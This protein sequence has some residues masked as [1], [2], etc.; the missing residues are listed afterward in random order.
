MKRVLSAILGVV[1]IP[2]L[3]IQIQ[4][5]SAYKMLYYILL[6]IAVLLLIIV[7]SPSIGK[8]LRK[9]IFLL[10]SMPNINVPLRG[11]E[12]YLAK[13]GDFL[14]D[15]NYKV[16]VIEGES[17]LGKTA[18]ISSFI[19]KNRRKLKKQFDLVIWQSLID[20]PTMREV[21]NSWLNIYTDNIPDVG[22]NARLDAFFRKNKKNKRKKIFIVF[23][24]CESI[25]Q[26]NKERITLPEDFLTLVAR[27]VE[28][29]E[30]IVK[31]VITSAIDLK[32]ILSPQINPLVVNIS[33]LSSDILSQIVYDRTE[34]T[35]DENSLKK[36]HGNPSA[37]LLITEIIKSEVPFFEEIGNGNTFVELVDKRMQLLNDNQRKLIELLSIVKYPMTI[38]EIQDL[39]KL[40]P[41]YVAINQF[42]IT[43]LQQTFL[44][45]EVSGNKYLIN[46]ILASVIGTQIIDELSSTLA[47]QKIED[48][49]IINR[50][51]LDYVRWTKTARNNVMNYIFPATVNKL[52]ALYDYD[53]NELTG[54][55][56]IDIFCNLLLDE[57]L[58]LPTNLVTF[59]LFCGGEFTNVTFPAI[60]LI[61]VDF[62]Q[63]HMFNT[64]LSNVNII[65]CQFA[66]RIGSAYAVQFVKENYVVIGLASGSIE[67]RKTSDLLRITRFETHSQPI[68]AICYSEEN[69]RII[70]GG[71]DGRI[72]IYDENL[73]V[74]KSIEMHSQWIWQIIKISENYI[75]TV[76]CGGYIGVIDLKDNNICR[77]FTIPSQRIWKATVCEQKLFLASED[78]ILWT[79]LLADILALQQPKWEIAANMQEPIKACCSC[80]GRVIL[81]CRD[82]KLFLINENGEQRLLANEENCIRDICM[83]KNTDNIITVGDSGMA[84]IYNVKKCKLLSEFRVQSSRTWSIDV[85]SNG[86]AVTV[87]DD[88]TVH[89]WDANENTS[90]RRSCGNGQSLRGVDT[91]HNNNVFACADDFLRIQNRN[92]IEPWKTLRVRKRILG[93]VSLSGNKWACSFDDGI[94]LLGEGQEI[95][96]KFNAHNSAIESIARNAD[97]TM[98]ATGGE[99]RMIKVFNSLGVQQISPKPL[100]NSRIWSLA[101]SPNKL[102][103]ASAGGDFIVAIW[104]VE[105]GNILGSCPGHN[106]LVLSLCWLDDN[107]LVS[108]GTDGTIQ[109]WDVKS[110]SRLGMKAMPCLIR[111]LTTDGRGVVYGVGRS[112]NID[113]GWV[114]IKWDV[115]NDEFMVK[116][117]GINGGS[118]K[119]IM[120][121]NEKLYLGG[122][123]PIWVEVDPVTLDV[124]AQ[125]RIP[126]I[127]TGMKIDKGKCEGVDLE[128]L[129]LLGADVLRR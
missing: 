90:L 57:T 37:A 2:I 11:R 115:Q 85:L 111:G 34:Y 64:D 56:L 65:N 127:Y 63:V 27:L 45:D 43:N 87:G 39:W 107:N 96:S 30:C 50:L 4:I 129:T 35:L 104:D 19:K 84:H 10:E 109:L 83:I 18:I 119:T 124:I 67:L 82:G 98:F 95:T 88:R 28:Y 86:V 80:S 110:A 6:S 17:G 38:L 118:G 125:F 66:D 126:G 21:I 68:R 123:M 99:D 120:L 40:L 94:V 7:E 116:T 33:K 79:C 89:L 52:K 49:S 48:T 32:N 13:I 106:N 128:C 103:L 92:I 47:S 12:N 62:S 20:I 122:D 16:L 23:D 22:F 117:V 70:S 8:I 36:A 97:G 113:M 100:H 81:G 29:Q 5:S 77:K 60:S 112:S 54:D 3:L 55:T 44:L 75:L 9:T 31:I 61:G 41:P 14:T 58:F 73:V 71:E 24:N 53:V 15:K 108:A 102:K 78:G 46:P 105:T 25:L 51:P 91:F 76:A 69:G 59:F 72:V 114:V 93:F 42:D 26:N 1:I 74:L 121:I 101:F